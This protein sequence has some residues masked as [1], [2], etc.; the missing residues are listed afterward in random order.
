MPI[1]ANSFSVT[2]NNRFRAA[3]FTLL[4]TLALPAQI[5]FATP[6]HAND[7]PPNQQAQI[8]V[9]FA[10][11]QLGKPYVHGAKGPDSY[12]C[13][14]LTWA[15]YRAAGMTI[16]SSSQSQYAQGPQIARENLRPGDLVYFVG[17]D[18][19]SPGHV[20]IYVGS[21]VF[22]EAPHSGATVRY[23][24]IDNH[25]EYVGATRPT[26]N[27]GLLP[28]PTPIKSE[29]RG[30]SFSA[31]FHS[32]GIAIAASGPRGYW[33]LKPDGGIFSFGGASWYGPKHLYA[34]PKNPATALAATTTGQGYWILYENGV[35][36]GFGDAKPKLVRARVSGIA[37]GIAA[38]A[39]DGF[40]VLSSRGQ[41]FRFGHAPKLK[42]FKR[43]LSAFVPATAI[44]STSTG[45]GIWVMTFDGAIYTRGD[46]KFA[47]GMNNE[48]QLIY[49]GITG[50]GT[51]GYYMLR[52]DGKVVAKHVPALKKGTKVRKI[53]GS[54]VGITLR[55][56]GGRLGYWVI[57]TNGAVYHKG[58]APGLGNNF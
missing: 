32:H 33:V 40:W 28:H 27:K 23:N 1:R 35:V 36:R 5:I 31:D 26:W 34:T 13:S 8:A 17:S 2:A 19:P 54:A 30:T 37:T 22:I 14:G 47:G 49:T 51:R 9:N 44:A 38:H 20:G 11:K 10:R 45:R 43:K 29:G 39:N 53:K 7:T 52:N 24:T 58:S 46:A 4:V 3:I 50:V 57:N 55:P 16:G 12:D 25:G 41:I 48:R 42:G 6:A 56:G 18:G 21:G 15:S